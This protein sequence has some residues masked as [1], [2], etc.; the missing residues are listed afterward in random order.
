MSMTKE[1]QF[2]ITIDAP[3]QT[4]WKTMLEPASYKE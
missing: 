4:V 2:T 1:L 3:R